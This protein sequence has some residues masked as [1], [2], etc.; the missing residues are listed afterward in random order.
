M[1]DALPSSLSLSS[2]SFLLA[3]FLLISLVGV[4][5]MFILISIDPSRSFQLGI[6]HAGL[7]SL[8][9]LFFLLFY[10]IVK[11]CAQAMEVHLY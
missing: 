6:T 8:L 11:V 3:A 2:F 4:K 9:M 5:A 1:E 10:H 7:S